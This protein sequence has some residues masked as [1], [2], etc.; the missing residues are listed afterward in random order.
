MTKIS[1]DEFQAF[2]KYIFDLSGIHLGED[3][4]YLLE[5]RLT[6]LLNA[7]ACRTYGELLDKARVDRTCDLQRRIIEAISTNETYFF[8]DDTPFALLRNKIIPDLIDRRSLQYS[9]TRIPIRIWSAACSTGQE[10]YSIAMTLLE[11]L[12][13]PCRYEI[14]ILGTDISDQVI[15]RASY[16]KYNQFEIARGLPLP[17]RHKY[18]TPVAGEWRIKDQIRVMVQFR[19]LNLMAPFSELNGTFDLIFCRNVAIYF[20]LP[21]KIK[22]FQKLGQALRPDGALIVG[23]SETLSG[24][25]PE[26]AVCRYLRGVYYQLKGAEATAG[27]LAPP[28]PVASG[29]PPVRPMVPPARPKGTPIKP[30]LNKT[31]PPAPAATPSQGANTPTPLTLEGKTKH[32]PPRPESVIPQEGSEPGLPAS[33]SPVIKKSLLAA[34]QAG[35]G[36]NNKNAPPPAAKPPKISLLATL[37]E[38]KKK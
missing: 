5:S 3:K 30:G 27:P 4:S 36:A 2:A 28:T 1:P 38:K 13:D 26:F 16:G 21:D 29:P 24:I 11:M 14:S 17:Y 33:P 35:K 22:L 20:T 10:V 25:A 7:A 9:K 19:K 37:R 31:P 34:L 32:Q 23:G 6:P 18:F 15:A 12:P 8:R